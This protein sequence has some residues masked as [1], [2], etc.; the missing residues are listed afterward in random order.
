MK[1]PTWGILIGIFMMLFGGCSV[2][3]DMQTVYMPDVIEMQKNM[4]EGFSQGVNTTS[5]STNV[6]DTISS[7][8][9][10]S[11]NDEAFKNMEKTM[12]KMFYMSDFTKTWMVR[13]GYIGALVS[14]VYIL[15]G[16][17][18]LIR[19]DY[20]IKLV[21]AVLLLSIAFAITKAVV[22]SSEASSGL[23]A[24]ASGYSQMFG[25]VIDIVFLVVIVASDK[26]TYY[27][28]AGAE[29]DNN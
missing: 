19:K 21:Y 28:I 26:T 24:F 2:I 17:F 27:A 8:V 13:F 15:G 9:D 22:L 11:G 23:I 18:L 6:A 1:T 7:V 3:N 20:S 25:V 12:N 5:D 4:M 10:R 29:G 16:V 14:L